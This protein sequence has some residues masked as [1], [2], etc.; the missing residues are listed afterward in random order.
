MDDTVGKTN[1][2]NTHR[3]IMRKLT[4]D[5][6][7]KKVDN[8]FVEIIGKYDGYDKKLKCRCKICGE[9]Y[10]ANP[11]DIKKGKKHEKCAKK[12]VGEKLKKDPKVFEEQLHVISPDIEIKG[13]YINN[14]TKI[15]CRCKIHDV[16]FYYYPKHLLRG[17]TGCKKCISNK[18]SKLKTHNEFI[19]SIKTNDIIILGEYKGSHEKIKTKCKKCGHIW[20]PSATSLVSGF[21]CPKCN[22]SKGEQKISEILCKNNIEFETQKKYDDLLGVGGRKLSYDFYIP[23]KNILIEYQGNFHDGSATIQ[24]E[25]GYKIQIEHDCRKREYAL[26]NDINL[27]EIWYYN[28]DKI[29]EIIEREVC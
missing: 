2:I 11:Y 23:N 16:L 28:Y 27:L 1:Y 7:I 19:D 8:P 21:G 22:N 17:Q 5:E 25:E 26:K 4:H 9:T 14:E 3:Y 10:Y 20:N 12:I 6:F 29:D 24:T 15:E 18:L 13:A